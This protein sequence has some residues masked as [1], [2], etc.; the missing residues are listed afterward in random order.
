MRRDELGFNTHQSACRFADDD[1][2]HQHRLLRALVIEEILEGHAF[3]VARSQTDA[4]DHLRQ[5]G[6]DPVHAQIGR[7][8]AS[9]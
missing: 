8:S 6:S 7:A 3:G 4:F 2:I 9:T 1:Q 5:Q